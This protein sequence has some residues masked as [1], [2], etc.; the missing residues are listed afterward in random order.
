MLG[1]PFPPPPRELIGRPHSTIVV[2]K[3]N[4]HKF[5]L[6]LPSPSPLLFCPRF[7]SDPQLEESD[8]LA[9]DAP[10]IVETLM[11]EEGRRLLFQIC[12]L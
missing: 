2:E 9:T 6:V 7:P 1:L 5:H 8:D 4:Q 12:Y 10:E 11:E 3:Q